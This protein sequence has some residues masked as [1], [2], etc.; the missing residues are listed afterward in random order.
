ML[1]VAKLGTYSLVGTDSHDSELKGVKVTG[2]FTYTA[3][4]HSQSRYVLYSEWQGP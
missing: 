4:T 1:Y 3:L 2:P